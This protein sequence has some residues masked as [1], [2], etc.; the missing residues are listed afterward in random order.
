MFIAVFL[1]T[2]KKQKQPKHALTDQQINTM[3]SIHTTELYSAIERSKALTHAGTQI[4][5]EKKMLR[6][7]GHSQKTLLHDSIYRK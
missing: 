1:I 3:W 5:L 7:R 6:E 2:A 4:N